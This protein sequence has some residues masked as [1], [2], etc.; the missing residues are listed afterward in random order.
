MADRPDT[1]AALRPGV[2]YAAVKWAVDEG[3]SKRDIAND[4][5]ILALTLSEEHGWT[6]AEI[7]D[8]FQNAVDSVEW[9]S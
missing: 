4:L 3:P 2:Y 5:E 7:E 6:Y 8:A 1:S 9:H